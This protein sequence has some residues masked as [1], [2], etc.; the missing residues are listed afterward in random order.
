MQGQTKFEQ[1]DYQGAIATYTQAIKFEPQN[2]DAYIGRGNARSYL[3]DYPLAI[4]DYTK[5]INISS[6]SPIAYMNRAVISCTL[7]NKQGA[8]ENKQALAMIT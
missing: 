4:Q 8:N 3:K 1:R 2:T 7:G 6:Q 5:V